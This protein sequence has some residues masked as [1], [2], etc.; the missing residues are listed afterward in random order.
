MA[1]TVASPD[2]EP[3]AFSIGPV[4]MQLKSWSSS[5]SADTSVVVTADS[6]TRVDFAVLTGS[7]QTTAASISG[8]VATF[9]IT[10]VGQE[11]GQVILM[12]R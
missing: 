11:K 1:I 10:Q 4:K 2:G 8:N 5:T 9:T 12:G 3:R 6:M 7:A